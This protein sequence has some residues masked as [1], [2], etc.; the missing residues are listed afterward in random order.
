MV[1]PFGGKL[2]GPGRLVILFM[3]YVLSASKLICTALSDVL[4]LMEYVL[5]P[6]N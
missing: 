1:R 5:F 4:L 2:A 6:Q 3:E